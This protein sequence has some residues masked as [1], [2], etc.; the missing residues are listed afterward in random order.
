MTV[1]RVRCV[2][3]ALVLSS[4]SV[5]C[6]KKP[7]PTQQW[8]R[9][10]P[11]PPPVVEALP[12]EPPV[13]VLRVPNSGLPCAVEEVLVAKCRRCHTQ[14]M[15]HTA[16]FPLLTWDDTRVMLRER[17]RFQ[18]MASAVKS[19][20]MP[21]NTKAN[22]PIERLTDAEK[23]VI[24]DWVEAGGPREDCKPAPAASSLNR[25]SS[26]RPPRRTTN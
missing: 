7:A 6:Q 16:P 13:E 18:V 1:L 21:Y 22:P 3:F 26:P 25:R 4:L 11:E 19:G 10:A 8:Q 9:S 15:R 20:F 12:P 17:P 2:R 5:G 24:V 23:R 14:P